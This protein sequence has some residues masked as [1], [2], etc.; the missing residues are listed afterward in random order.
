MGFA[1]LE[2]KE[3]GDIESELVFFEFQTDRILNLDKSEVSTDGTTK[4]SA[5]IG[6]PSHDQTIIR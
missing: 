6:R 3:D 2:T 4:I 5:D 1:R